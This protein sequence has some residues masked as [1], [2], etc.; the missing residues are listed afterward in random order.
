MDADDDHGT[1][2][3]ARSSSSSSA[4]SAAAAT[5]LLAMSAAATGTSS[6]QDDDEEMVVLEP[7][8]S[9]A[10]RHRGHQRMNQAQA[11]LCASLSPLGQQ[12][13]WTESDPMTTSVRARGGIPQAAARH[14][15]SHCSYR[16]LIILRVPLFILMT[17]LFPRQMLGAMLRNA[18]QRTHGKL[19]S[20]PLSVQDLHVAAVFTRYCLNTHPANL[21]QYPTHAGAAAAA[22]AHQR[23]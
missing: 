17:F 19:T 18:D 13:L 22:A 21:I 14:V 16:V 23:R 8:P 2:A 6:A 10:H 7:P 12:M 11:A 15:V 3:T 4:D 5:T 20:P 1:L 9:A